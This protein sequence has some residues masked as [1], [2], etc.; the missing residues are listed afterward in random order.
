M[1]SSNTFGLSL[2]MSRLWMPFLAA[3]LLASADTLVM[4]ADAAA[5]VHDA[6]EVA[7]ADAAH[8]PDV[9]PADHDGAADDDGHGDADHGE[10][11][12]AEDVAHDEHAGANE[13][14]EDDV[15]AGDAPEEAEA[16][17]ATED[18]DDETHGHGPIPEDNKLH[19][20]PMGTKCLEL[21]EA[22]EADIGTFDDTKHTDEVLKKISAKMKEHAHEMLGADKTKQD[23]E[24]K[25]FENLVKV[26]KTTQGSFGA[27]DACEFLLK[28]H[29]EL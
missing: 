4:G 20:H 7:D 25:F 19:D 16:S 22:V 24:T 8:S 12:D 21:A 28:H 10:D 18:E 9:V 17:E 29:E 13:E 1:L 23:F 3:A 11:A 5:D 27:G 2:T 15:P 26:V 14:G 6:D